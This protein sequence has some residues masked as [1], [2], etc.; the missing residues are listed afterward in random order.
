M[1][2]FNY[3]PLALILGLPLGLMFSTSVALAQPPGQFEKLAISSA[4]LELLE[5][6]VEEEGVISEPIEL[7][8]ATFD[9][10]SNRTRQLV[11]RFDGECSAWLNADADNDNGEDPIVEQEMTTRATA[12]SVEVWIEV[13][14]EVVPVSTDPGAE[15]NGAVAYCNAA[16]EAELATLEM[17]E[18]VALHAHSRTTSGFSWTVDDAGQGFY[19]VSVMAAINVQVEDDDNGEEPAPEQDEEVLAAAAA[20]IF[21]KRSLIIEPSRV[22]FVDGSLDIQI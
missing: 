18:F 10:S 6:H 12:A 13:N 7:L 4:T 15:D 1:Q 17:D 20:A 2:H 19:E 16:G 5:A 8:N 22:I 21:G 14:G 3:K 9:L 11:I